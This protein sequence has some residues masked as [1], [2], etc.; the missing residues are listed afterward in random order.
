M[1][2]INTRN[3]KKYNFFDIIKKGISIKGGLF[4]PYKIPKINIKKILL[5][6]NYNDLFYSIFKRFLSKKEILKINLKSIIKK[7]FSKKNFFL[8]KKNCLTNIKKIKIFKNNVYLY[9][10]YNGKSGSFKD[11]AISFIANLFKIYFKKKNNVVTSTSGDTGSSCIFFLRKNKKINTFVLS[12]YKKISKFQSNQMFSIKKKNIF[13]LTIKGNFDD[14]Q[15]IIKKNI[16]KYKKFSTLNSINVIRIITQSI[17]Y[18]N[19]YIKIKK[20]ITFSIPTG[21]F[22]NAYSAFLAFKMG[23]PIKKI[24]LCNNENDTCYRIFKGK[25]VKKKVIKTNSP[26]MDILKPSNLERYFYEILKKKFFLDYIKN[27]NK[28]YF[29]KKKNSIFDVERCNKNKRKKIIKEV[30]KKNNVI[31]D[32][33]T[34][35]A[36]LPVMKK[37]HKNF[38]CVATAS[39]VK[40][41]D[42][43]FK[44]LRINKNIKIIK[45]LKKKRK[46]TFFFNSKDTKKICN[47]V[48]LNKN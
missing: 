4:M 31:I 6:K 17:Y 27:S 39:Y 32:T 11:M 13:N 21:N 37:K 42:S 28:K 24:I 26:S 8:D 46:K 1:K 9:K 15:R 3:K 36:I 41:T 16:L 35:N 25:N 38:V 7:S 48:K 29:F 23:L 33:H 2:F 40:F 14:C 22:G 45:E 44:I 43:I 12:P 20:P 19:C 5:K 18:F 10:I 47:F 34:A 30:Y